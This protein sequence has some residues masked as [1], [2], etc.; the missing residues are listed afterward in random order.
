MF[1]N[2]D[3]HD[4][5]TQRTFAKFL[6]VQHLS[7]DQMQTGMVE[8]LKFLTENDAHLVD[9]VLFQQLD[10]LGSQLDASETTDV[11]NGNSLTFKTAA[12]LTFTLSVSYVSWLLKSGSLAASMLSLTPL[13]TPFDPIPVLSGSKPA[14]VKPKTAKPGIKGKSTEVDPNTADTRVDNLFASTH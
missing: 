13:W 6:R 9:H 4:A 2:L 10:R 1:A 8:V 5:Q 12:G 11:F 3:M 14:N 7:F